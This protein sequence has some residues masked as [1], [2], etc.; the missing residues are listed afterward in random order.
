MIDL[1]LHTFFSDGQ[2]LPAELCRRAEVKGYKVLA[3]TDHIDFSNVRTVVQAA[4]EASKHLNNGGQVRVIPGA[5]IT[6]VVP[7]QI[8]ALAELARNLGAVLVVVH[9]ETLVEPVIP[10]TNL[11][12]VKS[13]I[14]ILAHPGLLSEEEAEI[15]AERGIAIELSFRKGHCLGNGLTVQRWYKF[16]FPLVLNT[17]THAPEDLIDDALAERIIL[18]AGVEK[19]DVKKVLKA[20]ELLAEK[21]IAQL[22]L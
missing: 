12:A 1:H 21:K 6:H 22:K 7:E 3:L 19:G 5:E 14:D 13:D 20:S 9:G 2:L 16:S 4:V 8:P 18:A 15:A 17:D 10:G 11:S